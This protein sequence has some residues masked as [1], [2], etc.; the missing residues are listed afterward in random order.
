[1]PD[2]PPELT[3]DIDLSDSPVVSRLT[4]A[5]LF[6]L[7]NYEHERIEIEV[8]PRGS[9][10]S[11]PLQTLGEVRAALAACR[12]VEEPWNLDRARSFAAGHIPVWNGVGDEPEGD[13][14]SPT[15]SEELL[16]VLKEYE[17][18]VVVQRLAIETLRRMGD[19]EITGGQTH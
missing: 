13:W 14:V 10:F 5:R 1:M 17:A 19:V 18:K 6:N 9:H 3:D 15:Q 16:A 7:G 8:R 12:P 11:S 2:H 4:V